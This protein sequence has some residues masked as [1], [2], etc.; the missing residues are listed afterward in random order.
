MANLLYDFGRP[1]A[2]VRPYIGAGVG[3][4][5]NSVGF[6][7]KM[8]G[9]GGSDDIADYCAFV[10]NGSCVF[11]NVPTEALIGADDQTVGFA[12]QAR[13]GVTGRLSDRV[14][15]DV[16]YRLR[17]TP[18]LT[19]GTFNLETLVP[20]VGTFDAKLTDHALSLGIRWSFG[21]RSGDR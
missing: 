14:E 4:V 19:I 13:L 3:V 20:R 10:F 9:V 12:A 2:A 6:S 11:F 5:L 8:R 18:S 15:L 7:G 21:G 1:D 17:Y 16:G